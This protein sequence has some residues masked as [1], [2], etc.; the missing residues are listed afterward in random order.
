MATTIIGNGQTGYSIV[1]GNSFGFSSGGTAGG[2]YG[3]VGY[4]GGYGGGGV[5]FNGTTTVLGQQ[6][7]FSGG[8]GITITLQPNNLK[9]PQG[10]NFADSRDIFTVG[11]C[12]DGEP[13]IHFHYLVWIENYGEEYKDYGAV[14][15]SDDGIYIA[16]GSSHSRDHFEKW[17]DNYQQ[18][19]F[20]ERV[21]SETAFPKMITSAITGTLILDKT[22]DPKEDSGTLYKRLPDNIPTCRSDTFEAWAWIVEN[23]HDPVVRINDGWLF[24]GSNDAVLFRMR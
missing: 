18:T 19:F 23:C 20:K 4:A 21:I 7:G 22:P 6:V 5:S 13:Y 10:E 3:G 16:F 8:G 15:R 2:V 24:T 9:V 1:G 14:L 17:F 11:L 12:L